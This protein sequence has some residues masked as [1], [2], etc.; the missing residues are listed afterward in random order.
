MEEFPKTILTQFLELRAQIEIKSTE[1]VTKKDLSE[2]LAILVRQQLE[3][4][5]R[6]KD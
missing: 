4:M 5:D 2:F 1:F 3:Q 6:P